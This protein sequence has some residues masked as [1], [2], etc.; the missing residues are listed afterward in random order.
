VGGGGDQNVVTSQ[1]VEG[2]AGAGL[3]G[4]EVLVDDGGKSGLHAVFTFN[5]GRQARVAERE[6]LRVSSLAIERDSMEETQTVVGP[7][8]TID[9]HGVVSVGVRCDG[10]VLHHELPHSCL[11]KGGFHLPT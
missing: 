7:V 11:F 4:I 5:S 9:L 6:R 3:V 1:K 8:A 10:N 2:K